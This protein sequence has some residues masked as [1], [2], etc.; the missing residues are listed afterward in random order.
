MN[1]MKKLFFYFLFI[2]IALGA[3]SQEYDKKVFK[4]K[5]QDAEY[6]FL[7]EDY[8]SALP[9]FLELYEIDSTNSNVSY[10]IGICY[11]EDKLLA[12][13]A[14]NYLEKA[15]TNVSPKYKESSYKEIGA[16]Y[17]AY[18]FLGKALQRDF[19]FDRAIEAFTKYETYLKVNNIFEIEKNKKNIEACNTAKELLVQSALNFVKVDIF[20]EEINSAYP[21]YTPVISGDTST[22]IFTS[23]RRYRL[24]K[25][26]DVKLQDMDVPDEFYME[27]I[28]MS[29]LVDDKWEKA[30]KISKN[31]RADVYTSVVSISY[32]GKKLFL[33]RKDVLTG[34]EDEGNI[35]MSEWNGT[36]WL[37]ME[38]LNKNINTDNW[39]THA[40]LSKDET[41]LYFTSVRPEGFGGL[42]IY[43]SSID[44]SGDWGPAI[45]LGENINT[46]VDEE[47]PFILSDG[48]TLYFSSQGHYNIGGHD[49]FYSKETENGDWSIPINLGYPINTMDDDVFYHP[50]GDG[51]SALLPL[52]TEEGFGDIDIYKI[53]I[54]ESTY[55]D[56]GSQEFLS[57]NNDSTFFPTNLADL[58]SINERIDSSSI[59]KVIKYD[60]VN[61]GRIIPVASA[62]AARKLT[63]KGRIILSDNNVVDTTF[64][65]IVNDPNVLQTTTLV[66]PE[67]ETGKYHFNTTLGEFT[68]YAE[69]NGYQPVT[70]TV[71]IPDDYLAKEMVVDIYMEA[72]QVASGEYFTIKS[73]F[74]DYGKSNLRR[75]SQIEL[76]KLYNLMSTNPSLYI[77]VTGHTDSR[78]SSLFNLKLSKARARTAIDYL[79]EKDISVERFVAKG[80]GEDKPLAINANPDGTDN[81]DGRQFNRRVD[82][83]ILKTNDEHIVVE[84]VYI[85]EN[86]RFSGRNHKNK[87]LFYI[88]VVKQQE[89]YTKESVLNYKERKIADGYAYT[90][91]EFEDKALALKLLTTAIDLG[92]NDARIIDTQDLNRMISGKQTHSSQQATVKEEDT[93]EDVEEGINKVVTSSDIPKNA[94]YA[95][96]VKALSTPIDM[97]IF[98]D[99]KGVKE[100]LG[101]DG[102]YRYTYMEFLSREE[103]TTKLQSVK[104]QGY[105]DAFV[106]DVNR[107]KLRETLGTAEYTIQI[108]A[109][110]TP[111][112]MK[113]FNNIEGVKE[114]IANDGYY[115]Y[116]YGK[117]SKLDAA[118]KDLKKVKKKGYIDAFIVNVEKYN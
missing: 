13:H 105:T 113:Y 94:V 73:I 54:S 97:S 107:Y 8:K 80:M 44:E 67:V 64:S 115:K 61:E 16:Y 78:S 9:I 14:I 99:L 21:D 118:K 53:D 74:F 41:K 112:N 95:I 23:R 25:Q 68:I 4:N 57:Q 55:G 100:Y 56:F 37:P 93:E 77:E 24:N 10:K 92:F 30:V 51:K 76:E 5:F 84:D 2:I 83:K 106:I 45:N 1:N 117:Y 60:E 81:P 65:I 111:L 47:Y 87:N 88:L 12:H 39:E 26:G 66:S 27:D 69:G 46:S 79:V 15:V 11:T 42:D 33:I 85:P 19:E 108:K 28:Y 38:K 3:V 91:G 43:V 96:Q 116:I 18:Y 7:F 52:V 98:K 62:I 101:A 63:I 17:D 110:K 89:Q 82:I 22:I 102:Y 109:M 90:V 49:I 20:L 50:I 31:I 103:A 58:Y 59:K 32:D 70:K 6:F 104:D 75:E 34:I 48:K 29:K 72:I 40:S 86:L 114:I 36:R 35:Y 71:V